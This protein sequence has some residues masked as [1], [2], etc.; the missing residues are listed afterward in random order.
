M[1]LRLRLARALHRRR[2]D[3][4]TLEACW[5]A[6]LPGPG[7][8][9]RRVPF[10]ACDGEMSSLEPGDGELLS[11]GW[12]PV[13][14][15]F[16]VLAGAAHRI[17]RPRAGV[18]QSAVVHQLRDVDLAAGAGAAEV[19]D[20]FLCAAR[21]RVLLFHHARLDLAFL[22]R[23]CRARAGAPLL[24]PVVD[25]L[26]LERRLLARRG[27]AIGPGDL[28]LAGC[29][30]RYGLPPHRAHNALTDALATAE[31]FLAHAT[32]RGAGVRLRDLL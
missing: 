30:S 29:R 13:D 16:A 6:P 4:S 11:L 26:T 2:L 8:D 21:G 10:L 19:L 1:F 9:W 12:V 3:A 20:D 17:L 23:L 7:D 15:G 24:L 32:A 22:D 28:T 18:G 27:R 14:D 31:L 5:A 25:T